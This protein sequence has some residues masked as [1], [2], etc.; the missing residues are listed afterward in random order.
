MQRNEND[1]GQLWYPEFFCRK[2]RFENKKQG[3]CFNIKT[4]PNI[5]IHEPNELNNV[6]NTLYLKEVMNKTALMSVI[7]IKT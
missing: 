2:S 1:T 3:S 4:I 7:F 5:S 6:K